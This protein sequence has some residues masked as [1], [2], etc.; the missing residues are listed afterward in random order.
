MHTID[1]KNYEFRTDLIIEDAVDELNEE[2]AKTR[3]YEINGVLVEEMEIS[4]SGS[5]KLNRKSG[6]YRTISFQ[7]I[8]D[9]DQYKVVEDVFI[10]VFKN[11]LTNCNIKE[12]DSA[13][14]V[15]LG[16]EHSTPDAL[17]PKA[18]DQILVTRHLFQLGDVENGYRETSAFTPD[19]TGT[20]GIETGQLI[21]SAID[22]VKPQ[23]LIVIDALK[24][25]N[26]ERV[27][28][29]I[30]MSNTGIIPGSGVGNNREELSYESLGIPVI[31]IG[32]PTIVD[33][34]T[35]VSDTV[36]YIY[37]HFSYKI[38]HIDS[39][40]EKLIPNHK[41]NYIDYPD[42]LSRKEKSEILGMIGNLD[43]KD[44]KELIM[45]VLIPINYNLM[46]TP[47]EIDFTIDRLSSLLGQG[48][49][50]SLHA[51]FKATK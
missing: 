38:D 39:A 9:K 36:Q 19:V 26:I 13:L 51:H 23:F 43:D 50:K 8:T 46:V 12:Q 33:L 15:G 32:V 24:A 25:T 49:N 16:N 21:K 40:K 28:K 37:K 44:V 30:Q 27:T 17:G 7:D 31:V 18:L 22:V 35:V 41:Q 42:T 45:E 1:L 2:D 14:I 20:T 3:Q 34:V 10:D 47:K 5:K 4:E 48:I 6:F 11:F 29:T